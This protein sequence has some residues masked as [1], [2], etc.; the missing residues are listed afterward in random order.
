VRTSLD[1]AIRGWWTRICAA[2]FCALVLGNSSVI[3]ESGVGGPGVAAVDEVF[4]GDTLPPK[5]SPP[6]LPTIAALDTSLPNVIRG[7]RIDRSKVDQY[8][9]LIIPEMLALIRGGLLEL[10]AASRTNYV[11]RIDDA[12]EALGQQNRGYSLGDSSR[13]MMADRAI[14]NLENGFPFGDAATLERLFAEMNSDPDDDPSGLDEQARKDLGAKLLWNVQANFWNAHY[15][16]SNFSLLSFSPAT[17]IQAADLHQRLDGTISRVY[18]SKVDTNDHTSQYFREI[19]TLDRPEPLA[20]W[21]WL[22]FRFHGVDEDG[23]WLAS[24]AIKRSRQLAGANR[25]DP[26]LRTG[27]SP[28]DLFGWS[29][30]SELV[31]A[32]F[33]Q[34]LI[35]LAPFA[36]FNLATS[37]SLDLPT[38]SSVELPTTSTS[39]PSAVPEVVPVALPNCRKVG[40]NSSAVPGL[41]PK[42]NGAIHKFGTGGPWVPARSIFVPRK[43]FRVELT[44]ND[45]NSLYGRQVLYIDAASM[46]PVYK[47]V[48]DRTGK[49]WKFLMTGFGLAADRKDKEN[50]VAA[51]RFVYPSYTVVFDLQNGRT[52]A[53]DYLNYQVCKTLPEGVKLSDF[54]PA[55]L[56]F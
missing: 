43:L 10:D 17:S 13:L 20:G 33:D 40:E 37:E 4:S 42:W 39:E 25:S 14:P 24:P 46:L 5:P 28:D 6:P 41:S 48:Y 26:I 15:L 56:V 50:T 7:S 29:G 21:R 19:I 22:T 32:R 47:L 51:S 52:S 11:W 44:P 8:K 16:R 54:D 9:E 36:D 53:I 45:A 31:E 35:A 12:W 38:K 18:P 2:V 3:A 55:R 1:G 34:A 23:V 30:R 49:F 27:I